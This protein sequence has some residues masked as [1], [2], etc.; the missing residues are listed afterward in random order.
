MLGGNKKNIFVISDYGAGDPAFGEVMLRLRLL[1]PDVFIYPQTTPPFSTINTGF[2]IYQIAL[3][4]D[5]KDTFIYSNTAPRREDKGAQKNNRGEKLMYAKLENGVEVM[6]VNAG[7]VFSFIKPHIR[8][9]HFV[10][11]ENEGSQFRSRDKYPG[12]VAQMVR[13][14]KGF[15]G[16]DADIK[17]IP[18]YPNH[19]IA[20][21]DGYGN[22]KTTL[23]ASQVSFKPGSHLIIKIG[24]RKHLATYTDGIFNIKYG[25]LA[26]APGSSGHDDKFME[27]FLRGGSAYRM[28]D[29][30]DVEESFSIQKT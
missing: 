16:P 4:K 15:L 7:Y 6:A 3:T 23:R 11:V 20:S 22:I 24:N 26:L 13:N 30:P 12:A 21:I 27:V 10:N 17:T 9:F 29:M 5:V 18:D 28:F 8:S 2:W 1:L 25:E 19:V 14:D